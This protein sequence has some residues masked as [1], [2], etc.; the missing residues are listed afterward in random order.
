MERLKN[1][2]LILLLLLSGQISGQD[3]DLIDP[4]PVKLQALVISSA[5][6][7]AVPYASVVL[8]R[9]HSGTVTNDEGFFSLEMLNIDSLIISSVGFQKSVIKIP[10][11][12]NGNNVLVFV[13]EPI[14]YLIGEI[15]VKSDRPAVDLGLGTGKPSDI[16][17][18]LRGDAF[19][20]DPPVLAA[21]F[22]PV[23]Y[24][25]Y[26][27]SRREKRKREIREAILE[28]QYWDMHSK[29]YNKEKVMFLTGMTD[30]QADSFMVWL[31][32]LD[33]LPYTSTEYE[34][35]VAIKEYFEI[36]KQEGLLK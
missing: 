19:N 28:E 3:Y 10:N 18:E 30:A 22:S 29:N 32:S 13:L 36:Y 20:E 26:Y 23:S 17:P 14:V 31:N 34:V 11:N 27:L 12:Y 1:T 9:T 7:S 25:Q 4:F 8:N 5:D 24:M 16:P 21:V 6:S 15:Q 2:V 33:V 35:R